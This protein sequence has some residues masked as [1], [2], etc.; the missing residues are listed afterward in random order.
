[1]SADILRQLEERAENGDGW[2]RPVCRD[3]KARIEAQ[4]A[5]IKALRAALARQRTLRE[6]AIT[7]VVTC[8]QALGLNWLEFL[9]P[10]SAAQETQG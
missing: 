3:A 9:L 10:N 2:T 1:M 4:D 8:H 5:E 7:E 6:R